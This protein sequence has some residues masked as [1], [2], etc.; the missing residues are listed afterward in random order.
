M[1]GGQKIDDHSFW[2][3]G[4]SK[5]SVFPMQAKMKQYQSASPGAGAEN[6]YEDTTE[7]LKSQQEAGIGKAKGRPMKPLYRN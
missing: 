4:R 2:A 3:G 5:E 7:K 1:A 6:D